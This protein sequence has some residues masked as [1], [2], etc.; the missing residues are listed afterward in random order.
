MKIAIGILLATSMLF[1]SNSFE[2]NKEYTCLNT[3]IQEN[4]VKHDADMAKSL[5]RPFIFTIKGNQLKTVNN[6]AFDFKMKKGDMESYSNK[7][8]MLLLMKDNELG[9]VPKESRGQVQYFFK[10]KK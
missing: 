9:L 2:K 8:F 7:D 3:I 10:C 4:G 1:A 5:E 6:V